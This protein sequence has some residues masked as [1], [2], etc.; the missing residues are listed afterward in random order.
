MTLL[1][2]AFQHLPA[3]TEDKET[4]IYTHVPCS[5]SKTQK[6]SASPVHSRIPNETKKRLVAQKQAID[7]GYYTDLLSKQ[8]SSPNENAIVKAK[9]CNHSLGG[10]R[11]EMNI[12]KKKR[13]LI[14]VFHKYLLFIHSFVID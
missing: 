2:S 5:V 1:L 3:K 7:E 11:N 14:P 6:S 8:N 12:P 4:A 10:F 13:P 9:F